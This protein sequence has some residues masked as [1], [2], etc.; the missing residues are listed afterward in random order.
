M[1]VLRSEVDSSGYDL[2]LEFNGVLRYVQ[3][4]SSSTGAKTSRQTVNAK[5]ADKPGGCVVWLT[6]EEVDRRMKLQYRFYGGEPGEKPNLGDQK[7][8]HTRGAKAERPNTRVLSKS[9]FKPV[10]CD[11]SLLFDLLFERSC[12]PSS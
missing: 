8:K 9:K 5:L 2:A 4:K 6:F 1:E 11:I 3:L 12:C 10:G 7:G